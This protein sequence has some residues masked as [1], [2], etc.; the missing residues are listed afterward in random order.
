MI[1]LHRLLSNPTNAILEILHN[2]H[3]LCPR[4]EAIIDTDYRKAGLLIPLDLLQRKPASGSK[5]KSPTVQVDQYRRTCAM[6][7]YICF[8]LTI[9]QLFID[10]RLFHKGTSFLDMRIFLITYFCI[11]KRT[12]SFPLP[13][14][15]SDRLVQ[16]A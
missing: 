2:I 4:R 13:H 1:P 8:D 16:E 9:T 11:E 14:T 6:I 15:N 5:N 12:A 7:I 10:P 3:K